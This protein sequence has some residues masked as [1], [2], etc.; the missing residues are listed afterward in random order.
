MTC[1]TAV[2]P[3]QSV[4]AAPILDSNSQIVGVFY[5]EGRSKTNL[6]PVLPM[7]ELEAKLF[8]LL[9]YGVASGL[10]RVAQERKLIAERA[11][12]KGIKN[13]VFDRGGNLYHGRIAALADAA[14]K[15]GLEF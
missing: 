8:E 6:G 13:V 1:P 15:G 11:V 2:P 14:R 7:T 9:A 4:I 10:A 3:G 5:G 12:A